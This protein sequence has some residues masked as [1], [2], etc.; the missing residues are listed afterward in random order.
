[1]SRFRTHGTVK[2]DVTDRILNV[3]GTGPWN[4]ESVIAAAKTVSPIIKQLSG[5]T[6]GVLVVL[7]GEPIYVS[8]AAEY[9]S[10]AI[11]NEKKLGRVATAVIVVESKSPEFAK[12]HLN[13]IYQKAGESA[14][15]FDNKQE[16]NWWLI[17]QIS[18]HDL[19]NVE[20]KEKVATTNISD[21][22]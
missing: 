7:Y 6:W 20:N 13:Q 15:F 1:M 16:A 8:G 9:L 12:S 3:E 11:K 17:Q 21:K 10:E 14:R 22:P 2:L 18:Q 19:A 4:V 5:Q